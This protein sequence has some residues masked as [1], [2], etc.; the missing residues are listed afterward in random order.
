MR[1]YTLLSL[2]IFITSSSYS[3]RRIPPQKPKLIVQITVEQLRYDYLTR[4]WEKLG[5]NGIKKLSLYGAVCKNAHVNYMYTQSAPGYA[6]IATGATPSD[7]GV[8]SDNWYDRLKNKE[9]NCVADDGEKTIGARAHANNSSPRRLIST[10]I[11]DELKFVDFK[12]KVLSIST[13]HH[14]AIL[15]AGHIAD[16]VYWMDERNGNFVT[17]SFYSDAL[18]DWVKKFNNKKM[19]E[20]Y[21]QRKWEP[22]L[23]IYKYLESLPD[24][25]DYELGLGNRIAFDYNLSGL[26]S[27]QQKY[28]ILKHTPY[29]SSLLKDFAIQA[30][31]EEELGKDNHTD[32]LSLSFTSL[33]YIGQDF[34]TLSVEMEDAIIKLDKDIEFFLNFLENEIGRENVVVVF[35]S[36]H[37]AAHSPKYLTDKNIP[38]GQ[39]KYMQAIY[40]LKSYLN[41]LYGEG[42]WVQ[43]YYKHQVYLNHILIENS[44]LMLDEVQQKAAEFLIQV[45]GVANVVTSTTLQQTN[46]TGL[47]LQRMQNSFSQKLSGDLLINLQAGWVEQSVDEVSI[48]NSAYS[49]D[50]HVP[51]IW[52]GWKIERQTI[53]DD[54]SITDIA[55]TIATFLNTTQPTMCTGQAIGTLVK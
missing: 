55:P 28:E 21:L 41:A 48:H 3:Q 24:K 31:V 45:T 4:F 43:Y 27:K 19:P 32:M 20:I 33:E 1:K 15:S 9:I 40:L 53:T 34:G 54:I 12:S 47:I 50:T 6:S 22:E 23:P 5:D 29:S 14:A 52:Y 49:Y 18:P 11:F 10:T 36:N 38:A 44:K 16:G 8:I 26:Y 17:S 35:T 46:F 13:D 42:E 51:L 37:G 30:I 39:F 2:L 7:H 25:N